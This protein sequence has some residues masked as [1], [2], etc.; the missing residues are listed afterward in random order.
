MQSHQ[1]KEAQNNKN[2]KMKKALTKEN[3]D[4]KKNLNSN[5]FNNKKDDFWIKS[6]DIYI[7]Y[8]P[9]NSNF[10]ISTNEKDEEISRKKYIKQIEELRGIYKNSFYNKKPYDFINF[11][12]DKYPYKDC[13]KTKDM[14]KNK[15]CKKIVEFI[16]P[17]YNPNNYSKKDNVGI[18]SE[19][20]ILLAVLKDD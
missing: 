11:I 16:F 17:R 2:K 10:F 19:I 4:S 12:L 3:L 9:L 6:T 20:Y 18:Y 14:I 5:D 15:N 1:E 8:A 13:D 7:N